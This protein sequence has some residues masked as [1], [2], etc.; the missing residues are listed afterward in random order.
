M[1]T[2][3]TA[4][5]LTLA[6]LTL[7]LGAT[8]APAADKK[9]IKPTKPNAH[10][11]AQSAD[12][13]QHLPLVPP[14]GTAPRK[15]A[16]DA[17]R[18]PNDVEEMK[19]HP[20]LK[21]TTDITKKPT[22]GAID[23]WETPLGVKA[24]RDSASGLPTGRT[25]Q[26]NQGRPTVAA[27]KVEMKNVK[28]VNTGGVAVQNDAGTRSGASLAGEGVIDIAKGFF[29]VISPKGDTHKGLKTIAEG[30]KKVQTG[31]NG[32]PGDNGDKLTEEGKGDGEGSGG[33]NNNGGGSSSGGG[34]SGGSTGK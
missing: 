4:A 19:F 30:A 10:P 20:S 23:D 15:P 32:D 21:P 7:G 5:R 31:T 6:A 28:P 29:Q 16:L 13:R 12:K 1:T 2:L 17:A 24:A 9:A 18:K 34:S 14:T 33:N 26:P 3:R 22:R 27:P 25:Q 11:P 8:L